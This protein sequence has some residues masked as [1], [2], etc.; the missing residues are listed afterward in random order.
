MALA[1]S[2]GIRLL[3][4]LTPSKTFDGEF[5]AQ[6]PMHASVRGK[7]QALMHRA[8]A[9]QAPLPAQAWSSVQQF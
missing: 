5:P 8:S 3:H 2:G 6:V 7:G 4:A 9:A 1:T